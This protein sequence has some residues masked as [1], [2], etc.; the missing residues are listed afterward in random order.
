MMT[1]VLTLILLF[2]CYILE[3]SAQTTSNP[4]GTSYY[5]WPIEG[6]KAGE[7]TL[8]RPQDYIGNEH[9]FEKLIIGAKPG[10]NVVSPCDGVITH[11]TMIYY[12]SL[13][14]SFSNSSWKGKFEDIIEQNKESM[15]KRMQDAKYLSYMYFIKSNDGRTIH[16]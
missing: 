5:Q 16:I 15:A 10:T 11:V 2:L 8:Y 7:G 14:K 9:N 12:L 13:N 3:L 4:T 6:A 1:R